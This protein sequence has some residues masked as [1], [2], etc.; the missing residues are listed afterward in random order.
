MRSVLISIVFL[1]GLGAA[2]AQT[3]Y[4]PENGDPSAFAGTWQNVE[5][6]RTQVTR[7][8]I[9]PAYDNRF[10][11]T[12]FGLYRG[13]AVVFGTYSGNLFLSRYPRER[14]GDNAA[15]LVKVRKQFV[16][17]DVLL[18]F[19]GRGEIVSHALLRFFDERG[20][21]YSVDRFAPQDDR[22]SEY[23]DRYNYPPRRRY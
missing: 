5:A 15:I 4:P 7:I 12:V 14:E 9:E 17:G 10:N 23:Q 20:D 2:M 21:V 19:N 6:R 11:V 18:R 13:E 8:I 16:S 3:D 22:S 1:F